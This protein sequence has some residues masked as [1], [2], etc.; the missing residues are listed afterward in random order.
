MILGLSQ[1]DWRARNY[2]LPQ[3][4]G[5]LGSVDELIECVVAERIEKAPASVGLRTLRFLGSGG[6]HDQSFGLK[7]VESCCD[8]CDSAAD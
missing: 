8:D 2:L 4:A 3:V 1:D 7:R 6:S 5:E